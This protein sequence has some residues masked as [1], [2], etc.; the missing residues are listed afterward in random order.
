[1]RIAFNILFLIVVPMFYSAI[2]LFIPIDFF[3]K[4]FSK[5]IFLTPKPLSAFMFIYASDKI[6]SAGKWKK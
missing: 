2:S 4:I 6:W 5:N 3:T 1:M